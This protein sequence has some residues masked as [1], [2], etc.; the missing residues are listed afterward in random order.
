MPRNIIT[1]GETL[2]D[3]QNLATAVAAN[4]AEVPH[5]ESPRTKLE[6]TL[7]QAAEIIALQADLAAKRQEASKKLRE[8]ITEGR[9]LGNFLRV[10]LKQH[11]GPRSE[12]LAAFRMQPF[13]GFK[14]AK[15][16]EPEEPKAPAPTPAIPTP[17]IQ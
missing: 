16:G 12:K 1:Q 5:L 3:L 8:L 4:S 15:P 2:Q 14:T 13:R 7:G 9:R 17:Q 6:T 10:G 11:Y